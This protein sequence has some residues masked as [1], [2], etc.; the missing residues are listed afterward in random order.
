MQLH[1][2]TTTP[3]GAQLLVCSKR[4]Y[5]PLR[6]A[7][8]NIQKKIRLTIYPKNIYIRQKTEYFQTTIGETISALSIIISDE[9]YMKQIFLV[10][11]V[12]LLFGCAGTTDAVKS[13]SSSDILTGTEIETTSA[14][15]A[16]DAVRIKRPTFL[17]ARGPKAI[18]SVSRSNIKPVV[19]INGAYH[20]ELESLNNILAATVKEIRYIEPGNAT[21]QYG[22]GH[23]AGIIMVITK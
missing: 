19:Y 2:S 18:G 7:G 13:T 5:F 14:Y 16:M 1:S 23:V 10:A 20:G 6:A 3:K 9:G 4:E 12:F 22:S 17:R 11:C 15:S 8:T 21:M